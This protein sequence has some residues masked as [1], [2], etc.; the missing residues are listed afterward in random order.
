MNIEVAK[1]LLEKTKK[2]YE[3]IAI[4]FDETRGH[5]PHFRSDL[6]QLVGYVS[7]GN[8]VL[9][10]GSGNG[11]LYELL[12]DK[13]I[14]YLGIDNC[15]PLILKAKAHFP[16]AKFL[17]GDVLDLSFLKNVIPSI[18]EGFDVVFAIALLHHIPSK[19]LRLKS[20]ENIKNFLKP[21]GLFIM[22]NWNLYQPKYISKIIK[23]AGLVATKKIIL[24]WGDILVP[25]H[26]REKVIYRYYHAFTRKEISSLIEEAGF[27]IV[28]LYYVR[29]GKRVNW[30]GGANLVAIA[31][32]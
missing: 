3:K 15:A 12:K 26:T 31:R 13:K 6:E 14:D 30:L 25:W 16:A 5:T 27:T 20:L 8:K 11:R 29:E 22:S 17:V 24:D 23:Y 18:V 1:K 28:D 7:E 32:K 4:G 9:E 21:K 2:D 10:L 19:E